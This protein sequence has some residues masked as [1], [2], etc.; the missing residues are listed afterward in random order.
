MVFRIHFIAIF[1][2]LKIDLIDSRKALESRQDVLVNSMDGA[3]SF[4]IRSFIYLL[5][6]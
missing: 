4:Y 5:I 3:F 2:L 6:P 1:S